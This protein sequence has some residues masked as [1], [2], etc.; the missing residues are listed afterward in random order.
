MNDLHTPPARERGKTWYCGPFAFAAITGNSFVES[1]A[2][3]N[4]ARLNRANDRPENRGIRGC[5]DWTLTCALNSSG[6]HP[7]LFYRTPSGGVDRK[8]LNQW[9]KTLSRDD[10]SIYLVLLTGHWIV[11]KGRSVMIDNHTSRPVP[12][13]MGPWQRKTV[14]KVYVIRN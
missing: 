3:L 12:V 4:R 1:R 5:S 8:N 7:S 10:D 13:F 11:V 6:Y 14:K 9:L 2:R